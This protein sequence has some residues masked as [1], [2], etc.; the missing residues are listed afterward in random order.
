MRSI[1]QHRD[2]HIDTLRHRYDAALAG[3]GHTG[4]VIGAGLPPLAH[5][6]DQHLNY[7]PEPLFV[8][9]VPLLA[10]PGSCI[11][12]RPG[13]I[14][15]LLVYRDT[16]Y[17][18]Q[19]T[20][21]PKGAW[22][23]AFDIRFMASRDQIARHL[24]RR[25]RRL[26]LLGEPSQ[27]HGPVCAAGTRNPKRLL[28]WLDHERAI[29]TPWEVACIRRATAT[30]LAGHQAVHAGFREGLSE[31]E[32]GLR[33]L[34]A[35]RQCDADLP[36]PAII[37]MN[38]NA[39]TL[40][41]GHRQ[42]VRLPPSRRFSLLVDA[43]CQHLGYASDITRTWAARPG[44]F[45]AM[46]EDMETLQQELCAL[47][48]PGIRFG[49]LQ[50]AAHEGI[51]ALLA[52]WQLLRLDPGE[53]VDRRLTEAF[54]PHGLGHLLGL[55]VHDVG[56]DMEDVRGTPGKPPPRFPRLRLTRAL[57][58]DMVLTIEPGVYFIDSL[59]EGLRRSR[60][61]RR[62]DWKAIAALKSCGGIRMEDNVRVTASGH[63]N[64]TRSVPT[65]A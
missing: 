60:H 63:E 55:Q 61:G 56:G 53:I 44:L 9:W 36:Y 39:A 62:V 32:L 22:Q 49:D 6:D 59:L 7:R 25:S 1:W 2:S 48:R 42:Q 43:G 17:W 27:W 8:Q 21:L 20:P 29:K 33:F 15:L 47:V 46:V 19:P 40:H 23:D 18:H 50:I 51:A 54:F 52:R 24:P 11:V 41:Y 38:R 30:A 31:Y 58:P 12:Y 10:H 64:I 26:A 4:V 57:E 16:G 14:P 3:C 34:T 45:S 13:H 37:A 65:R 5:R 35:T 28:R